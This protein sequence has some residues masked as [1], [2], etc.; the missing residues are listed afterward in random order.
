MQSY[1][2]TFGLT[3][4]LC[5][6]APLHADD[7]TSYPG[8]VEAVNRVEVSAQI[9]GVVTEIHFEPGQ[10]V[11]EGDMLFSFD[12]VEFAQKRRAA[13]AIVQKAE[14]LLEDARQEF[15]RNES[16]R[17]KGTIPAAR[18]AK[19]KTAV[20]IAAAVLAEAQSRL[21][22]AQIDLSR[23]EVYAPISGIVS[24]PMV[25][26]GSFVE[27]G[28]K[29]VLATIVQ[30]D[31]VRISYTIPYPDRLVELAIEDLNTIQKYAD[32]VDLIVQLTPDWSHPQ[33]AQP[34]YLS[35]DVSGETGSIT[36]WAI[37]D[38]P[39]HIL[40]PGMKVA[41]RPVSAE[42]EGAENSSDQ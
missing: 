10:Q 29:G 26:V 33:L 19:S 9:E 38:N 12:K 8:R 32:T 11:A 28:R 7:M 4:L 35:A 36:A 30:L 22:A 39:T 3:V 34:T 13:E 23:T 18:Y 5:L 24:P 41:V 40:R 15:A 1:I 31:P 17:S 25:S 16:L 27:T 20:A 14:A 2:S 6:S 37:V 42:T 21:E